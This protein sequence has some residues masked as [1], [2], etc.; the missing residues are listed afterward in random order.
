LLS[1]HSTESFR[2]NYRCIGHIVHAHKEAEEVK[3]LA[4]I[5][6]MGSLFVT[7][8]LLTVTR[9]QGSRSSQIK[10]SHRGRVQLPCSPRVGS[11]IVRF[12]STFS[13][14]THGFPFQLTNPSV[15]PPAWLWS[16]VVVPLRNPL[17]LFMSVE[18]V[19]EGYC[20]FSYVGP[21]EDS[22]LSL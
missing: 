21:W 11:S 8:G 16:P 10:R 3:K 13:S 7:F 4:E 9:V 1:L 12:T 14:T 5:R 18:W 17:S 15:S 20:K 19:L 2:K 22:A 6:R